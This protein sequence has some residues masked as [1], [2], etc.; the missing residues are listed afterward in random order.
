MKKTM[1]RIVSTACAISLLMELAGCQ[2]SDTPSQGSGSQGTQEA[3]EEKKE[4]T[5]TEYSTVYTSEIDSVNYLKSTNSDG[6][7]LFYSIMDGLIEFDRFGEMIPC[8]AAD[9]TVSNDE[10]TYTFHLRDDVKWY[11]WKGNAVGTVKAQN[12]V[13]GIKWILNP[14]H[15]SSNSKTVYDVIKNAKEFYEGDITDFSQVGVKAIDD[16]TVE[17]TLYQPTP[18]FIKELSF[19]CFFPVDG[20]FLE[21]QGE[22]FGLDKESILYC[23]AYL[24]TSYE[25]QSERVLEANPDYWNYDVISIGRL[26]YKYNSEANSIG[27]ELF[28]RGEINDFLLPGSILDEWMEDPEKKEMIRPNNLTNMS[29]FIGFNFDPNYDETY[30]PEDWKIAVNN[31]NFRQSIFHGF[32]REAAI[33]TVEPYNPKEKLLNTFTRRNLVQAD[34]VDYTMMGGLAA[35]TEGDSFDPD[36][37]L[38]YKEKAMAELEGQVTFP[39]Q[40]LVPFST[41]KVDT[42]NRMQVME[43]Q[44]EKL[45]GTDYINIVLE[46]HPST[47]FTKQVR[48][49]GA[50]SMMEM[51]WGPDFADPL[52]MMNPVHTGSLDGKYMRVSM[53][54]DLQDENGSSLFEAAL[55]KANA[56]TKDLKKRYEL[57]ADAECMLLDKAILIPF[58]TSGGGYRASYLD[59]FSGYTS[60]MGRNAAIKLKGAV[61][62]DKPMGMSEYEAAEEQYEKDRAERMKK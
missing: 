4:K 47:G 17:Y 59:P 39:I 18:Y 29:Y 35:Y 44:L 37:A 2:K 34:G 33:L 27:A 49:P 54:K 7:A 53:A 55:D 19:P 15:A 60:Q 46:S 23:G 1:L 16:T 14:D 13:D 50:Y 9:W 26:N 31:E 61:I 20:D 38:E 52:G 10:L 30:K 43:Q 12:F 48:T 40:I 24:L 3:Q 42:A 11:D 25:P 22:M 5:L 41:A 28:T 51:G 62:M 57:F 32:D 36:K 58:Y 45:L 6:I 56:E 21:E 8:I